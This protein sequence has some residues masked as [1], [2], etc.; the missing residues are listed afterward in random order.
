MGTAASEPCTAGPCCL[1]TQGID[2][3]SLGEIPREMRRRKT[4]RRKSEV[5]WGPEHEDSDVL[6][7]LNA[8][9][10]HRH[11]HPPPLCRQPATGTSPYLTNK[12][13]GNSTQNPIVILLGH[14][15][16]ASR[17][18]AQSPD[19][20]GRCALGAKSLAALGSGTSLT[21]LMVRRP[22]LQDRNGIGP[23]L[24]GLP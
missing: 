24:A 3:V 21:P 22:H 17:T 9:P 19:R 12:T 11:H 15:D 23:Y 14:L 2:R 10:H 6:V 7:K 1:D 5:P 16:L 8:T 13:K 20:A 18:A 4:H